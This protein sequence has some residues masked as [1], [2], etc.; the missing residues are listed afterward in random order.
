MPTGE[1][2]VEPV[3][4]AVLRFVRDRRAAQLMIAARE[5]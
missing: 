2:L 4:S 1:L 3:A 5:R